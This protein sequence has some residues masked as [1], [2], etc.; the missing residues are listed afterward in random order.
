M[1]MSMCLSL[2]IEK[3]FIHYV[4]K[5]IYKLFNQFNFLLSSFFLYKV[6]KNKMNKENKK[7]LISKIR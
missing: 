6:R 1:I 3:I 5:Q 7:S 4:Y 2:I